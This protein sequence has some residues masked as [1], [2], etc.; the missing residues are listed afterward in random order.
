MILDTNVTAILIPGANTPLPN[1]RI[2]IRIISEGDIDT[3]AYRLAANGLVRGDDDMIFYG[4]TQDDGKS[5]TYQGHER[6]SSFSIDLAQQATAIERIVISYCQITAPGQVEL[7][8]TK[9]GQILAQCQLDTHGR[10]ERALIMA[11]CY[12]YQGQWKLRFV[13]QGFNGG[14]KP[15]SEYF[16]V[17]IADDEPEQ[18]LA[19]EYIHS[20]EPVCNREEAGTVAGATLMD[21]NN[22]QLATE[23]QHQPLYH[24]FAAQKIDPKF[25]YETV[26]LAGYFDKAAHAIGQHYTLFKPILKRINWAYRNKHLHL[27]LDLK[28]YAQ[29]DAGQ[30]QRLCRDFYQHTLFSRCHYHK[31]EKILTLKL[32][33]AQPV[34]QFFCGIW[35]E[36]WALNIV[37]QARTSLNGAA[38]CARQLHIKFSNQDLYELDVI[39][40]PAG[41]AP[42]I[43]EC[44]TGEF[45]HQL[46]QYLQL[47]KRLNLPSQRFIVLVADL[48]SV[49]ASTLSAMYPLSFATPATLSAVLAGL[50]EQAA[51]PQ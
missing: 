8:V 7:R 9:Q 34:R 20:P 48:D 45:R 27:K 46:E 50:L 18:A 44:K 19:P 11:E 1:E 30:I 6:D 13:A 15:L 4:Q 42:L 33:T 47:C 29:Q 3:A 14:L 40:L 37:L 12:R 32:Q 5:I 28:K 38:A 51:P 23:A 36:W 41:A 2:T 10:K 16:G 22:S 21:T 25:D 49:Q 31:Q 17:D 35:L 43:I 39:L 24:W 26:N